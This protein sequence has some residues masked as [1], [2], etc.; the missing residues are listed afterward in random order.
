ML[1]PQRAAGGL[2]FMGVEPNIPHLYTEGIS[3]AETPSHCA[4]GQTYVGGE[5]IAVTQLH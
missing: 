1:L 5:A 2:L 4:A 3:I